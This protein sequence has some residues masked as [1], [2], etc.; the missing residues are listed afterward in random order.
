MHKKYDY[1]FKEPNHLQTCSYFFTTSFN[2]VSDV[3][4]AEALG[5][6]RIFYGLCLD[7]RYFLAAAAFNSAWRASHAFFFSGLSHTISA[8]FRLG[9]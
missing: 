9:S 2:Y 1:A 6:R 8:G 5:T 3:K 4:K 7:W